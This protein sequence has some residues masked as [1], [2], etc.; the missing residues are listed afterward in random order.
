MRHSILSL[1]PMQPPSMPCRQIYQMSFEPI[2]KLC[3]GCRSWN[4]SSS[5][6]PELI[7]NMPIQVLE[8]NRL[9][10]LPFETIFEY[11]FGL[12]EISTAFHRVYAQQPGKI[13]EKQSRMCLMYLAAAVSD[14]YVS[15]ADMVCHECCSLTLCP[16][17]PSHSSF[18]FAS[19]GT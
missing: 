4:S 15:E 7:R 19:A 1:S 11:L 13:D 10:K 5:I 3:C 6:H 14:F 16:S 17:P 8:E 9:L 18:L 2:T 12:R